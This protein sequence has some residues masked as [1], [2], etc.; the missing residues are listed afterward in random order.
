MLWLRLG[1]W[2]GTWVGIDEPWRYCVRN[3][4]V[5]HICQHGASLS[6]SLEL[7]M[8]VWVGWSFNDE[9]EARTCTLRYV[10]LG[11]LRFHWRRRSSDLWVWVGW[12]FNDEE[13]ARICGFGWVEVQWWRSSDFAVWNSFGKELYQTCKAWFHFKELELHKL[14]FH[15][16]QN[17]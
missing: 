11:R 15:A 13:E 10:G 9:E 17:T 12:G 4:M 7:A 8:W 5:V 3:G 14:E 1:C 6:S 2:L 16:S